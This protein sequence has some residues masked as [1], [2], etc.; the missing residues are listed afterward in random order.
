MKIAKVTHAREY[1]FAILLFFLHIFPPGRR[2]PIGGSSCKTRI[3]L[4]P[5]SFLPLLTPKP[6]LCVQ[7][8]SSHSFLHSLHSIKTSYSHDPPTLFDASSC[9]SSTLS[10][11]YYCISSTTSKCLQST[12]PRCLLH[13]PPT[14]PARDPGLIR[15]LHWHLGSPYPVQLLSVPPKRLVRLSALQ[16]MA[17]V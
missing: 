7:S 6:A 4:L 15:R 8:T 11:D 9:I 2:S 5:Q 10:I 3:A 14:T 17:I 16:R 1:I 12:S 13:P